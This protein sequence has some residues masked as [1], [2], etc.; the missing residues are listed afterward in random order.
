MFTQVQFQVCFNSSFGFIS[1]IHAVLLLWNYFLKI[2]VKVYLKGLNY[3]K[4]FC[5]FFTVLSVL[6]D[7]YI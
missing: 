6:F 5:Y 7:K 3:K 2:Q 1:A 4:F